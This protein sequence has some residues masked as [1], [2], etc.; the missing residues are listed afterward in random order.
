M[1]K[2]K[3]TWLFAAI[4]RSQRNARPVMLRI[5]TCQL[6]FTHSYTLPFTANPILRVSILAS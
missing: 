1:A 5:M 2:Q 4:N 3:C 6:I